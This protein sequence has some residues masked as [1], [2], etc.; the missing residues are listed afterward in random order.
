MRISRRFLTT[1]AGLASA[2]LL[3]T[4]CASLDFSGGDGTDEAASD[5]VEATP[6]EEVTE[7]T[8]ATT[9]ATEAETSE[10]PAGAEEVTVFDLEQGDCIEDIE[11]IFGGQDQV[12]EVEN[13]GI[14]DCEQPHTGEVYHVEMMEQEE[15]PEMT[16]L[17]S[18][19]ETA[20]LDQFEPFVGSPYLQ[21]DL[22]FAYFHPTPMSWQH[23]DHNIT[24]ML[25]AAEP[26]SGS[27]GGTAV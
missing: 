9:A 24:C 8:E 11:A 26:T 4:G 14:I 15:L 5:T 10:D 2:T 18:I 16:E 19:A 27:A 21:S 7:A 13:V 25:V 12:E 1:T 22:E 3:L 6:A 23:G 20:C 17:A